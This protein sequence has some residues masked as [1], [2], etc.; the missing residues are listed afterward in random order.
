MF[1][2]KNRSRENQSE[3]ILLAFDIIK[4]K[5]T[6]PSLTPSKRTCGQ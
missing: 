2:K 4:E 3:P 6:I 5:Q 1:S